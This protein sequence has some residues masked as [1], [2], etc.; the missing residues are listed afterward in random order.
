MA[1]PP[2]QL[3]GDLSVYALELG[4]RECGFFDGCRRIEVFQDLRQVPP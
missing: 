2:V 4:F 3:S 1:T